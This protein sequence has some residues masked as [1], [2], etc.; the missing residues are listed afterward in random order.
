M[1][2][3]HHDNMLGSG[4]VGITRTYSRVKQKYFSPK[5]KHHVARYVANCLKCAERQP[6]SRRQV[7]RMQAG[8]I[9]N[10]YGKWQVDAVGPLKVTPRGSKYI[11]T[12]VETLS[13]YSVTR[14][15]KEFNSLALAYFLIKDIFFTFSVPKYL[16]FDNVSVNKSNLIQELLNQVNCQPQFITPFKHHSSGKIESFNKS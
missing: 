15:V 5:L 8:E 14:P 7:G 10:L 1:L 2:Y 9:L 12:A 3:A 11:L 6:D 4:H 13:N 16:Q